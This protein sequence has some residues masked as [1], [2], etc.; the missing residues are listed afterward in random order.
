VQPVGTSSPGQSFTITATRGCVNVGSVSITGDFSQ[1]NNC[2]SVLTTGASCTAQVTF[3]PSAAGLRSGSL[4]APTD[5]T[6][7]TASLSGTDGIATTA[8]APTALD[9]DTQLVDSTS[10]ARSIT[11]TN[12]NT[13]PLNISGITVNGDFAQTNTCGALL[14]PGASCAINVTFTPA[15]RLNRTGTLTIQSDSTP[16][17]ANVPLSGAGIAPIPAFTPAAADFGPQRVGTAISQTLTLTNNGDAV[18]SENGLTISGS[19]DF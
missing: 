6:T 4:N 5:N 17:A 3:S 9:F 12:T 18:L 2:S 16:P 7:L 19:S 10:P 1:T 8:V 13:I 14:A 15:A 11:L